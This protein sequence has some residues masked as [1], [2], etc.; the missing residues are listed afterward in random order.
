MF[1]LWEHPHDENDVVRPLIMTVEERVASQ[2]RDLCGRRA[3]RELAAGFDG[4]RKEGQFGN[5]TVHG[6][7][8]NANAT[9]SLSLSASSPSL[10]LRR[11]NLE[12]FEAYTF[13]PGSPSPPCPGTGERWRIGVQI[14]VLREGF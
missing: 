6:E 2:I 13:A 10:V 8:F 12:G 7:H 3:S 11:R 14:C 5:L 4:V 1:L 9:P